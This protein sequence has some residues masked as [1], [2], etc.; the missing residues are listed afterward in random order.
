MDR[1]KSIGGSDAGAVLGLNKYRTPVDVYL[2]KIG[3][4]E[5]FEGNRFTHWGNRLEDLILSEYEDVKKIKVNRRQEVV[6]H[7]EHSFMTCTLDGVAW[8]HTQVEAK[9]ASAYTSGSWGEDGSDDV[10][11]SYMAQVQHNMYVANLQMT[12]VPVLIGGNDFRVLEI[13]R[14]EAFIEVMVQKEAD[15]WHNNVLK[16]VPPEPTIP[17]DIA[18]LYATTNEKAIE[19]SADASELVDEL[20]A[21]KEQLEPLGA[22]EKEIK[23]LLQLFMKDA[24]VLVQNGNPLA[25]WK[26]AKESIVFDKDRFK[27]EMPEVYGEYLEQK[28]GSRRFLVK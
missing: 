20:I 22:R 25:T 6:T 28:S 7:P 18:K 9:S 21:L 24:G 8:N 1:T 5:R 12:H 13:P 19:A 16:R 11:K 23:A 3:E 26:E 14:S 27:K 4:G 15:F 10:P 2:E 17:E